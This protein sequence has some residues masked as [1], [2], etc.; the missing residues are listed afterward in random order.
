MRVFVTVSRWFVTFFALKSNDD[1][2]I[3]K[4]SE[5]N[6]GNVRE[7]QENKIKQLFQFQIIIFNLK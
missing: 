5:G 1:P 2:A 6:P 3:L 7:K 4:S